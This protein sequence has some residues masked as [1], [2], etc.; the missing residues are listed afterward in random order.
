MATLQ[1]LQQVSGLNSQI[2]QLAHL[3]R[4]FDVCGKLILVSLRF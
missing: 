1:A 3:F 4:V 2:G